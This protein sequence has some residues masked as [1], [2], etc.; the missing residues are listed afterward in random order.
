MRQKREMT[1]CSTWGPG[2]GIFLALPCPIFRI[3]LLCRLGKLFAWGRLRRWWTPGT[4]GTV[5]WRSA[6]PRSFFPRPT[7]P[8]KPAWT[9]GADRHLRL[10]NQKWKNLMIGFETQGVLIHNFSEHILLEFFGDSLEFFLKGCLCFFQIA[11]I[12]WEDPFLVE[13][14]EKLHLRNIF[15][16]NT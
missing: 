8:A 2:C 9:A 5:P 4:R 10:L 6:A 12:S 16:N 1:T 11:S 14:L 7:R 13:I 15:P 3:W